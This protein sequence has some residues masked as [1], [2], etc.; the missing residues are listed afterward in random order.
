[1]ASST[2]NAKT[3]GRGAAA[4]AAPRAAGRARCVV[5]RAAKAENTVPPAWP[6]R[7]VPPEVKPR[8]GPKVREGAAGGG[9]G[10]GGAPSAHS[11]FWRP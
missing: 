11:L 4:G 3:A 7:A 1:M 8:N 6:R 10:L 2:M 5:A 9:A